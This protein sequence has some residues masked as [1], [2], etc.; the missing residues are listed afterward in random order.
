MTPRLGRL[1]RSRAARPRRRAQVKDIKEKN[2]LKEIKLN[3]FKKSL[4]N[5]L[6]LLGWVL[7]G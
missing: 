5:L 3:K 6:F 2:I 7:M 4:T 1:R